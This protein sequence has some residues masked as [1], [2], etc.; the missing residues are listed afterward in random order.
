MCN[1][2]L[3]EGLDLEVCDGGFKLGGVLLDV[4]TEYCVPVVLVTVD[5]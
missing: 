1:H 4:P 5:G 3:D 2:L